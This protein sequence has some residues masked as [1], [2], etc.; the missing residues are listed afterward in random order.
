MSEGESKKCPKCGAVF[1]RAKANNFMQLF[2]KD[3]F[4]LRGFGDNII[5]FYCVNCGYIEFYDEKYLKKQ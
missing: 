1:S 5:G 4:P 3:S 2:T